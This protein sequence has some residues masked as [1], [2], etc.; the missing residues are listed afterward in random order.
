MAGDSTSYSVQLEVA[1]FKDGGWLFAVAYLSDENCLSSLFGWGR[2]SD[3][4]NTVCSIGSMAQEL[5][6]IAYDYDAIHHVTSVLPTKADKDAFA[7]FCSS[8][9]SY[10]GI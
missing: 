4:G 10:Y 6:Q 9:K 7:Q 8:F 2:N 5:Q 3:G 1:R